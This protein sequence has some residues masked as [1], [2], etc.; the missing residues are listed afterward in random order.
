MKTQS[1][2]NAAKPQFFNLKPETIIE[3]EVEKNQA[4]QKLLALSE[5]ILKEFDIQNLIKNKFKQSR[6]G[7]LNPFE[8]ND[9][10]NESVTTQ[11][12]IVTHV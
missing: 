2:K 7:G 12:H 11:N 10:L 5:E 6:I 9:R 4:M 1:R 3:T 8:V